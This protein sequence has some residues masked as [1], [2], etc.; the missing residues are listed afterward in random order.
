MM[1]RENQTEPLGNSQP[2]NVF[3]S[4]VFNSLLKNFSPQSAASFM[5]PG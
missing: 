4:L 1:A 5:V 2:S 3:V